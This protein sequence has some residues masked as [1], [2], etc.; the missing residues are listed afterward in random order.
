MY[1]SINMAINIIK[2]EIIVRINASAVAIGLP[3]VF[4]GL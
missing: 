4:K 2:Q 3:D 1:F